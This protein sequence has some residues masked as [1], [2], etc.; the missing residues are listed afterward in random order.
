LQIARFDRIERDQQLGMHAD[1]ERSRIM[2]AES[3]RESIA[4]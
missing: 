2:A 3:L 4:Q 1:F